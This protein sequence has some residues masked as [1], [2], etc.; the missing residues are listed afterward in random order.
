MQCVTTVTRLSFKNYLNEGGIMEQLMVIAVSVDDGTS[1]STVVDKD[2]N[3][4][5]DDT[6]PLR[7]IACLD[8]ARFDK[9]VASEIAAQQ[10][11]RP[12]VHRYPA[13]AAPTYVGTILFTH[14]SPGQVC[15]DFNGVPICVP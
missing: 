13:G 10:M 1:Q 2:G 15:V 11:Q 8:S 3:T 14:N 12:R 5:L 7:V 9:W 6:K 4:V